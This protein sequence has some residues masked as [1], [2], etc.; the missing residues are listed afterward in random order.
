MINLLPATI[1]AAQAT[2]RQYGV[3]ASVTLAQYGLESSWGVHM[4]IGSNNPFGI[5]AVGGQNYVTALTREVI[6]GKSVHIKQKFRAFD[7]LQQ[8]FE[9]H[10]LLLASKPIYAPAMKR[11]L[12]NDRNG[13]IKLMAAHYATAPDYG[14]SLIAL[15]K[16][17]NLSQYDVLPHVVP[18]QAPEVP[19]Q[20]Q[21]DPAT[22]PSSNWLKVLL[23][24]LIELFRKK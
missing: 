24:L 9:A 2:Q 23:D 19:P 22:A 13:G 6:N 4:P 7:T 11:W 18:S 14:A 10:G 17:S 5:K 12:A 21:R 3:P 16:A 15:I 1:A 20:P 8:A